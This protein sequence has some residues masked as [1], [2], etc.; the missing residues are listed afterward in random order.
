MMSQGNSKAL[1]PLGVGGLEKYKEKVLQLRRGD[2]KRLAI[3][4][5]LREEESVVV[6]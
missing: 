2:N 5:K 6:S 3:C 1:T 4:L